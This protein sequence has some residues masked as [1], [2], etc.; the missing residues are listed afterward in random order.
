VS[1][2]CHQFIP[3]SMSDEA[4]MYVGMQADMLIQST[5][6]SRA[7]HRR[8]AA[9][10]GAISRLKYSDAETSSCSSTISGVGFISAKSL[11]GRSGEAGTLICAKR[12]WFGN[13]ACDE[14][15]RI[16]VD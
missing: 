8:R 15:A 7:D 9:E 3:W 11:S 14:L 13:S 6:I 16:S 1:T 2:A 10:I 12:R 5:A 4:S